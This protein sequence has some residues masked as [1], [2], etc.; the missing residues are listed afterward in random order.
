MAT[1]KW[2]KEATENSDALDLDRGIFESRDAKHI[3]Q[4]LKRS[5]EHSKRRKSS[6]FQ[7]AMSMLTFFVNRA[8]RNLPS[9][10]K[11]ILN[12]AKDELR[13]SFGRTPK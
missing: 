8:G 1:H 2:S 12:R 13:K 9:P 11:R 7:S 6:A 4:S 5:A 10:R 3:A